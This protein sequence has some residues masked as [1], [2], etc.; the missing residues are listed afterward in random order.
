MKR[1]PR[2]HPDQL[3]LFAEVVEVRVTRDEPFKAKDGSWGSRIVRPPGRGWHPFPIRLQSKRR[4]NW[5]RRRTFV[6]AP[7]RASRGG[8]G[9][10]R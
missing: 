6:V 7:R 8:G 4:T 10:R 9:W 2:P 3:A 5:L 1:A